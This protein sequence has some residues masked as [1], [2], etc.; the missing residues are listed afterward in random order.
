MATVI[1]LCTRMVLGWSRASH[2]LTSSFIDALEMARDRGSQYTSGTFQKLCVANTVTQSMGD[3]G[4]CRD[5]AV[6]EFFFSHMKTE[7]Y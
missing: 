5:E 2:M 1:D 7:M 3:A 6:A 4:V